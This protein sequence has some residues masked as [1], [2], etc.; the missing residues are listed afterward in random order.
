VQ[1]TL[2]YASRL[3]QSARDVAPR[4]GGTLLAT[5]RTTPFGA[6][7]EAVQLGLQAS[8]FLPGL[9]PHHGVRLRGGY[10]LQ[11]Q[12]Q[13]SFQAAVS[14]PRGERYISFDRLLVGSFDYSLPLAYVHWTVERFLYIQRLKATA[15]T[16]VAWGQSPSTRIQYRNV[17][18]DATVL[19]N[20]LR[21]R[22]PAEAGVRVVYSSYLHNWILEPLAFSFRL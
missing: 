16:D 11:R 1:T 18:V 12:N 7:L 21:L 4:G 9:G 13:Y 5:W 2:A 14:Y 17:G 19:F 6:G 10:Q 22:T 3:K 20:V 15:F 8:A